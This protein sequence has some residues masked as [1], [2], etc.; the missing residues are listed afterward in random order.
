MSEDKRPKRIID[1][2]KYE[3]P[4]GLAA[5]NLDLGLW[6]ANNRKRIYKIIIIFLILLAL[7]FSLYS[8]Y[9]YFYYFVFGQEQDRILDQDTTSVDLAAYR[10]QNK[11][12]DLVMKSAK[13]ISSNNGSD[14]V[15]T[16][17]NPNDKQF[18][19]FDFCFVASKNKICGSSFILP[20]EEKNVLIISNP[21]KLSSGQIN[22]ELSNVKWQKLNAGDI[23][24]WNNFKAK[25]LI[26]NI[27]E[28]KFSSYD[29]N[30]NYLEFDI[31][32][33]S[34]YSYFEVPLNITLS[35]GNDIIAVNRYIVK[36]FSSRVKKS[37]RL[38]W[39]EATNLGGTIKIT[40]DL[41]ITNSAIYK[42]Y[43]S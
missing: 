29:N 5:K 26:F 41:N 1:L 16:L 38:S 36:D 30:V 24:N 11:P 28:P 17:S 23:P 35:Q 42:P 2:K 34:A 4:T 37:I 7:G 10:A 20:S 15:A 27:S 22:L 12:L 25:Y 21:I 18:A 43:R 6:L 33:N 9:G 3:D 19:T 32:N 39:P 8:G 40:P 31:S 14:F 13:V